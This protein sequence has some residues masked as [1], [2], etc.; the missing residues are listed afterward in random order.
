MSKILR[1]LLTGADNST[2]DVG[3]W[4]WLAGFIAYIAF[5]G[6]AILKGQ[7]WDPQEFAFGLGTILA[8]GGVGVAVKAST[9]P[10]APAKTSDPSY[11]EGLTE[12][13]K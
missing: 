10:K 7:S 8:L 3:R 2:H 12:A 11:G 9:E 5:Q 4:L 1:Q 13:A 6:Y